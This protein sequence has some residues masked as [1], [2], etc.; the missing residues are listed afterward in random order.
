MKGPIPGGWLATAAKLPGKALA[1]ALCLW[2]AAGMVRG[3]KI[4]LTADQLDYFGL[5]YDATRRGLEALERVGLVNVERRRGRCPVVTLCEV[6][7][8]RA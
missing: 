8:E 7:G 1:V 4:K 2:T 6:G 3:R 5:G